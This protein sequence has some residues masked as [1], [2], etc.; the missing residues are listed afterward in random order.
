MGE[1]AA[2]CVTSSSVPAQH[3]SETGV[4]TVAQPIASII[5]EKFIPVDRSEIVERVLDRLFEPDQKDLAEE[6]LRYM[7]ALRQ[8][9]LARLLDKIVEYYDAFNPD[10]ETINDEKLSETERRE[11]LASLKDQVTD[12]VVSANYLEIDQDFSQSYS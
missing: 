5:A 1:R 2:N 9:E 3:E 10:D 8:V 6:V 12:L 7:C 4:D 11:L